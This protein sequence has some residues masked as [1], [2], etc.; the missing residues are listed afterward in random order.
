MLYVVSSEYR[1]FPDDALWQIAGA[2]E[3]LILTRDLGF[4]WPALRPLPAGVV[5]VRAPA[6]WQALQLTELIRVALQD[7]PAESLT[8]RVTLI[9]PGRVRQRALSEMPRDIPRGS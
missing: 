8:D 2:E 3:R 5:I 9:E 6:H 4:M 7:A 1:S